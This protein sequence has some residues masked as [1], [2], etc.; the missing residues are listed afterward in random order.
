GVGG[1]RMWWGGGGVGSYGEGRPAVNWPDVIE[2]AVRP[3]TPMAMPSTVSVVRSLRRVTSRIAFLVRGLIISSPPS[4]RPL[5]RRPRGR[6]AGRPCRW[7][8]RRNRG[9]ALRKGP[10][11]LAP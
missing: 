1:G 2:M 11:Y 3:I 10:T 9:R 8:G 7:H 4:A 6:R 5:W